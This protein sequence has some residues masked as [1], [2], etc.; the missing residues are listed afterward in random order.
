MKFHI[1]STIVTQTNLVL[2]LG[3]FRG[4]GDQGVKGEQGGYGG[5][6]GQGGQGAKGSSIFDNKG[7][8]IRKSEKNTKN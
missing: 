1:P 7:R 4:Q 8:G 2:L 5:Q 6:G 3:A